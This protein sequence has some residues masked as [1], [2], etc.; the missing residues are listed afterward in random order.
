LVNDL[1][2]LLEHREKVVRRALAKA[3]DLAHGLKTPLAVLAQEADRVDAEGQHEVA[4]T[5]HQQIERMLRQVDYH[6]AHARAA[7]SGGT[8]GVHCVVLVSV[9]GLSRTLL[10]LYADRGLEIKVDVSPEHSIRGQREDLDE[11]LGNLLDNACKWARSSVR[12][13]S[14]RENGSIVIL[15]DDDGPGIPPAM[16]DVV[17]QR[18]VR[19]DEAAPGSGFGLSIVCDLAE[20][21]GGTISLENSPLGGLR[22]RLILPAS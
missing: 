9:E 2:S 6:L 1:N 19:A 10:R 11:M 18:G 3:G 15:V 14:S 22:A 17:L 16:R 4:A 8:P 20:V 13:Q 5:V 21:Y 7:G 12:V